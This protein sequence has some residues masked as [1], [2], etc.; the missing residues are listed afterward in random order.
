[1][2]E[3]E[4]LS[5]FIVDF[6][7]AEAP[8]NVA[9]IAK[10][11]VLDSLASAVGASKDELIESIIKEYKAYYPDEN[12]VRVW[13]HDTGFPVM[14]GIFINALIGHRFEL[15]D[16]HTKS[17]THI[18]TIVVP[19]AFCLA[20][21]L[22][23]SGKEFLEAVICGYET[24]SR[25]G[26]GFGVASHR[27][28]GWHV[29]STAGTFGSAAAAAKLLKLDVNKTM[30]ALGMAGAQSFGLWAFLEDSASSKIL[31]P[32]RAAASGAEAAILARAGMT[33]P[34]NILDARD[35]GL[36]RA[37]SD[38]YDLSLVTKGLGSS[39]EIL[40]M[41]IKPYPCCRSTHCAIDSA[42]FLKK[43]YHP[44]IHGIQEIEVETYL[45]GYKQCGFT[46]GSKEPKTSAEAKFSTPYTVATALLYGEVTLQYFDGLK[47][48]DKKVQNLLK[49]VKV[50]P[51]DTFTNRYPEHWGCRTKIKMTNGDNFEVEIKDALG[52]VFN[53]IS[54][55]EI[56]NKAVPLLNVGCEGNTEAIINKIINIEEC[57]NLSGIVM[58]K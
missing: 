44:D 26:M 58:Y 2:N 41:D 46:A 11:C 19:T 39:Y 5:K 14:Q 35:G 6:N 18:G 53:P 29:T 38:E 9:E 1:M 49:K 28:K 7:L 8:E 54:K 4:Q 10:I 30:H 24:M 12:Q 55:N 16:V 42:L 32:A 52:S 34:V 22:N 40:N 33:G 50:L 20:Q 56:I 21:S 23:S 3:L 37:M 15:D 48:N 45:V 13:G 47:I 51:N 43:A 31:H 17:K 25:I 36:Y 27:N 57:N